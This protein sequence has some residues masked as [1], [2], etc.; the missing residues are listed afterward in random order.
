MKLITMLFS[1]LMFLTT[2][3]AWG[4][5]PET[6]PISSNLFPV[7]LIM[8]HQQAIGLSES[9]K[10]FIKTEV[11]KAQVKFTDLQ[12]QL[13]DETE[14]MAT[15]LKKDRVD[16]PQMLAQL[17]KILALEREI[18]RTHLSLIVQIKNM[19]TPDQQTLLQ[20]IKNKTNKQ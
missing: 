16:E 3:I 4:Q 5:Q 8:Q 19:L 12:F 15:L 6:D 1:L 7:E 17:D 9:Q 14:A 2:T 20:G 18:K 13:Q 11:R 10:T